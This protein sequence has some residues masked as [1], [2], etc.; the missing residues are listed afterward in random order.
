MFLPNPILA[1][2]FGSPYGG[3]SLPYGLSLSAAEQKWSTCTP[4]YIQTDFHLKFEF[5]S[6]QH[7]YRRVLPWKTRSLMS[8]LVCSKT[9]KASLIVKKKVLCHIE[10]KNKR[11]ECQFAKIDMNTNIVKSMLLGIINHNV[12]M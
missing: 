4:K 12:Y 9:L 8:K 7:N 6:V 3:V 2:L 5:Y 10:Y 1:F 11:L